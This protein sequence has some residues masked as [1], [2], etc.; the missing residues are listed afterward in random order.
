MTKDMEQDEREM[1]FSPSNLSREVTKEKTSLEQEDDFAL[2]ERYHQVQQE[3]QTKEDALKNSQ[4]QLEQA[5]TRTQKAKRETEELIGTLKSNLQ[6]LE[7]RNQELDEEVEDTNSKIAK[8]NAN[9]ER[10]VKMQEA[11]L[12]LTSRGKRRTK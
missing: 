9:F 8:E 12:G 2:I 11:I 6:N 10:M 7:R 3:V 1:I 4:L 5:E